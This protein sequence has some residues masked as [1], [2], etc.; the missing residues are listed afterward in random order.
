MSVS[1]YPKQLARNLANKE[2]L[3]LLN[4]QVSDMSQEQ[5]PIANIN[6]SVITENGNISTDIDLTGNIDG[7]V[8]ALKSFVSHLKATLLNANLSEEYSDE[9]LKTIV[10]SGLEESDIVEF[11]KF[12]IE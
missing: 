1:E 10:I 5:L 3:E 7:L 4:Q 8:I 2:A 9:F 12:D 6:L 11:D